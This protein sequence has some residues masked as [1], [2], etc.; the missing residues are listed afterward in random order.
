MLKNDP[1]Q[2]RN[3]VNH[4]FVFLVFLIGNSFPIYILKIILGMRF[5]LFDQLFNSYGGAFEEKFRPCVTPFRALRSGLGGIVAEFL[6]G[7]QN[8]LK[9][10]QK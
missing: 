6:I 5:L 7:N 1:I 8:P 10:L 9:G 3:L 2:R 4:S